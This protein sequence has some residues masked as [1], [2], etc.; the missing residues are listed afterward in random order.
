MA[1]IE[2]P[3]TYMGEAGLVAVADCSIPHGEP[4]HLIY[5][6][7]TLEELAQAKEDTAAAA[8][9]EAALAEQKHP[10]L[11]LVE[12]LSDADKEAL[13]AALA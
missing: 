13:K 5:R 6:E 10:L 8:A 1:I 7:R 11:S 12:S 9:A 4:G 3:E 2:D